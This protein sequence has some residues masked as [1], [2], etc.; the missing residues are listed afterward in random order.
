M[1]VCSCSEYTVYYICPPPPPPVSCLPTFLLIHPRL[2]AMNRYRRPR[3]HC[4]RGDRQVFR[5][6]TAAY[7]WLPQAGQ[8]VGSSSPSWRAAASRM[9]A[10]TFA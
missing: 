3:L 4:G 5:G 7:D 10:R 1:Y 2:V 8:E 9:L 6:G